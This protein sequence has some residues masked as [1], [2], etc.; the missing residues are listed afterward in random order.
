MML[1]FMAWLDQF[2]VFI[3]NLYFFT[4]QFHPNKPVLSP[5]FLLA[6]L[7]AANKTTFISAIHAAIITTY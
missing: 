4:K 7:Y 2:S 5:V 6:A 3:D 1:E